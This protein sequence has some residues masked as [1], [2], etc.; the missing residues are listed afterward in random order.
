[1]APPCTFSRCFNRDK[2]G[3]PQNDSLAD[4]YLQDRVGTLEAENRTMRQQRKELNT[5]RAAAAAEMAGRL[6]RRDLEITELQSRLRQ[7]GRQSD[8]AGSSDLADPVDGWSQH[9]I[10][11]RAYLDQ[12][13]LGADAQGA[14]R[15]ACAWALLV[16]N[17]IDFES[18]LLCEDDDLQVMN[19]GTLR[20]VFHGAGSRAV[21]RPRA[22]WL[23]HVLCAMA[24]QEIGMEKGIRLRFLKPGPEIW[25]E[26]RPT[27]LLPEPEP[28]EPM[29]LAPE[30]E[31]SALL[32]D[33]HGPPQA[34]GCVGGRA[35]LEGRGQAGGPVEDRPVRAPTARTILP[36]DSP[37]HLGL[38]GNA[39]HVHQMALI[40]SGCAPFRR[41]W[42]WCSPR[43]RC[44]E[45]TWCQHGHPFPFPS[46]LRGG[47][48]C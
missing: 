3:C 25:R 20:T 32:C 5:H 16:E 17:E 13:Q 39:L 31:P 2:Q 35:V 34:V 18:L 9:W 6:A 29:D 4:G 22:F 14:D 10:D 15:G 42:R 7:Q 26:Q 11:L 41:C 19:T 48:C 47:G 33:P 24:P 36:K 21:V 28:E 12:L 38:R 30:P 43:F 46:V 23:A 8:P 44:M 1:M 37:N 40:T 45:L 27:E